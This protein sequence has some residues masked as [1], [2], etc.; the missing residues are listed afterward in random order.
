MKGEFRRILLE[1]VVIAAFGSMIGLSVNYRLVLGALEG[2]G[3]AS[4]APPALPEALY[5][6]PAGVGETREILAQG[7][8]AVD[9][10]DAETFRQGHIPGAFSLPL[11]EAEKGLPAFRKAVSPEKTLVVYCSGYGCTDSFDLA[12]RLMGA[13]YRDVRVFEGGFPAWHDAGLPTAMGEK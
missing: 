12:V 6:S 7:G 4:P 2:K 5:P 11:G 13:G 1:A 8:V 9:A 3:G 10:R